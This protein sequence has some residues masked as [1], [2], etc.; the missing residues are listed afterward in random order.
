MEQGMKLSKVRIGEKFV[1]DD[2]GGVWEKVA[3]GKARCFFGSREVWNKE[4]DIPAEGYCYIPDFNPAHKP[5]TAD[6]TRT[7]SSNKETFGTRIR[8]IDDDN[9]CL[10]KEID[11]A[12]TDQIAALGAS[13][14]LRFTI[15]GSSSPREYSVSECRCDMD[16]GTFYVMVTPEDMADEKDRN[17]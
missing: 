13:K 3:E 9:E 10:V 5:S 11:N 12:S 17:D 1:F 14:T 2:R 16:D 15:D 7:V 6:T 4:I 8:I